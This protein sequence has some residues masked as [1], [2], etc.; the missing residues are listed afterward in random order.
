MHYNWRPFEEEMERTG[1]GHC[2]NHM[3]A[4]AK[5]YYGQCPSRGTLS[6]RY[7]KGVKER[8]HAYRNKR[9]K[10]VPKA[11]LGRRIDTFKNKSP[12]TMVSNT[13]TA[14]EGERGTL[15]RA[16]HNRIRRGWGNMFTTDETIEHLIKVQKYNPN[17]ETIEDYYS[18]ERYNIMDI[19]FHLDHIDPEGANTLDNLALTK[20]I[21]NQMKHNLIPS[22]FL[23]LM[24]ILL[25]ANRPELFK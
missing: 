20:D 6:Y 8:Q 21:Y 23:R 5:E 13:V 25:R 3:L 14:R 24:E 11:L 1:E 7:G 22:E 4:W 16:L 2:S 18:K 9:M 15:K 17:D 10:T 19:K 12:S